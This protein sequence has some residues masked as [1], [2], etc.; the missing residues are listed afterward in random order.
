MYCNKC[1]QNFSMQFQY[2][3]CNSINLQG[4]CKACAAIIMAYLIADVS[5]TIDTES[6]GFGMRGKSPSCECGNKAN[7]H[8]QGHSDWCEMYRREF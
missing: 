4:V 5:I 3:D 8:G 6:N 1:T 7:P 2:D